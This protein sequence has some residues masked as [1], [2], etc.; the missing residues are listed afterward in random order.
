VIRPIG[1]GDLLRVWHELGADESTRKAI[2]DL[3]LPEFEWSARTKK[4]AVEASVTAP[5]VATKDSPGRDANDSRDPVATSGEP[6]ELTAASLPFTSTSLSPRVRPLRLPVG[7]L[8]LPRD[9][10]V[11]QEPEPL[12]EPVWVRRVLAGLLSSQAPRGDVDVAA[13]L[14]R[15]TEL[16]EVRALPRT[17]KPTC[18]FGAQVLVDRHWS[19]MVFYSDQSALRRDIEGIGGR[20][21]TTVLRCDAF[22]P[23][24]ISELS[25]TRWR[26]YAPPI[27]GTPVIVVSDLGMS[28]GAFPLDAPAE[29][30]WDGFIGSLA[31]VGCPVAALVPCEPAL[32][33]GFVRARLPLLLWDA[34][35][36]PS[37][38]TRAR[39]GRT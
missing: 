32:Y 27:A 38:A 17:M 7:G 12:L 10:D 13:L 22:P 26:P 37:D 2:R 1:V 5:L 29:A 23:K 3:L 24:R 30:A 35:T 33:P 36:R 31:K 19:M 11:A 34:S 21:R 9:P 15:L 16:R 8:P 39:R 20:E 18:R 14:R 6:L 4:P 28:R 25:T